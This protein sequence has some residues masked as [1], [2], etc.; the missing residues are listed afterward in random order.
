MPTANEE[1]LDSYIRHQT[2]LI[3]YA[4]GLRNESAA[5]LEASESRI[6]D[7]I[8]RYATDVHGENVV[9]S[10]KARKALANL[11]TEIRDIRGEAWKGIDEKATSQLKQ[12]AKDEVDT[13]VKTMDTAVPVLLGLKLPS[14]SHLNAI[15]TAQPFEGR[16]LKEWLKR[17]EELDVARITQTAKIGIV[18]G[19]T[20]SQV[21]Q[22][23]MGSA[24]VGR[25]NGVV[26]KAFRDLEAV[27][28]T[29]TNGIQNEAKEALYQ[30][31]SDIIKTEYFV[32]TL[33]AR[34]TLECA[35]NDGKRFPIGE[36]PMPPLH[37]RCRSLRVPL[38][39]ADNLGPRGFDANTERD[40]VRE[41]AKEK[42][43]GSKLSKR[44][45]LPYG[46]KTSYDAFA[47]QRKKELIGTVP[48][49]TTY[50]EWLRTQSPEFQNNVL[51]P[52][53][54]AMFRDGKVSL[55]K[56]VARDGDTLTLDELRAS[57]IR[58]PEPKGD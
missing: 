3:R 48:G 53:R 40:L 50:Q 24:S 25:R 11:S 44:G 20:P 30:E 39:D 55:D 15:A 12:L 1:V 16:T 6:N 13:A 29:V 46:H 9:T 8:L 21:T 22:R 56:F 26:R 2:F 52:T 32:A 35:S 57:G 27:Y 36:G 49:K 58:I 54:A 51:G 10:P 28:L 41:Y 42:G 7:V 18:Q 4:G 34:T 38:F 19:D 47:R 31:N 45:N 17:T 37:F 14:V 23:V 33:D 5:L 43:L